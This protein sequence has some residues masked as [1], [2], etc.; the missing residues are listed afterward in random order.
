MSEICSNL[1]RIRLMRCNN[2]QAIRFFEKS[3]GRCP[4]A[5]MDGWGGVIECKRL[6]RATNLNSGQDKHIC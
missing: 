3:T 4:A 6:E 2:A 1:S 5:T